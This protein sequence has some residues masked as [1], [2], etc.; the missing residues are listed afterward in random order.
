MRI[1]LPPQ[2]LQAFG[3]IAVVVLTAILIAVI[4]ANILMPTGSD[5]AG[6]SWFQ[7]WPSFSA[8]TAAA[9]AA[10]IACLCAFILL[11]RRNR[12]LARLAQASEALANGDFSIEIPAC[13]R[14]DSL[15]VAARA[16]ALIRAHAEEWR[17]RSKQDRDRADT[18]CARLG[19][20]EAALDQSDQALAVIDLDLRIT[21]CNRRFLER[22]ELP[23]SFSA[24]QARLES[25]L[26]H[27]SAR[28]LIPATEVDK[29][30]AR[31]A[32]L[33]RQTEPGHSVM[34][35][36]DG[37]RLELRLK[38]SPKI[39]LVLLY[40]APAARAALPATTAALPTAQGAGKEAPPTS[41]AGPDR[42]A[43]A[44]ATP[45][46]AE[47]ASDGDTQEGTPHAA[48][49]GHAVS[50]SA[51]PT[52]EKSQLPPPPAALSST[53]AHPA[54]RRAFRV[55]LVEGDKS[56]QLQAI[57]ILDKAGHWVDLTT[58]GQEAVKAIARRSYDAVLID[59]ELTDISGFDVARLARRLNGPSAQVPI[60]AMVEDRMRFSECL[61]AGMDDILLKPLRGEDVARKLQ[62]CI[63]PK[64]EG[65]KF[66]G[67]KSGEP[68]VS[69]SPAAVAAPDC[70]RR[71]GALGLAMTEQ[72]EAAALRSAS[73]GG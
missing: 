7:T 52:S 12:A 44:S 22:L 37:T 31:W 9:L 29:Q 70:S 46:P 71:D 62:S 53:A 35:C 58:S 8:A 2:R 23:N 41:K 1:E 65:G 15:G 45:A 61:D 55:L 48:V 11:A 6:T 56:A 4:F 20:L 33:A 64:P 59:L 39:S 57:T 43:A 27:A 10:S 26:L 63:G 18:L 40:R 25:L 34:T 60:I 72:P 42:A 3:R 36:A 51:T 68:Q 21:F 28:G 69:G 50:P 5:S 24:G 49:D 16:I 38:P 32:A 47:I 73:G 66:S 19:R 17:S 30:M 14:S 13:E 67:S 54:A